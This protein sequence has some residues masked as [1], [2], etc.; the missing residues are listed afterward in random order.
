MFQLA[1][2][3]LF[4]TV[5]SLIALPASSAEADPGAEIPATASRLTQF[6]WVPL[7]PSATDLGNGAS[8]QATTT[9]AIRCRRGEVLVNGRCQAPPPPPP[10]PCRNNRPRDSR[11]NC[12]R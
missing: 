7:E 6:D 10:R 1:K 5:I 8:C 4:C 11:G 9:P 12:P 3:A 2:L